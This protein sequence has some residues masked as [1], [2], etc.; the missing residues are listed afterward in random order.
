MESCPFFPSMIEIQAHLSVSCSQY[1]VT[2]AILWEKLLRVIP[3]T[4][5]TSLK[6]LP[7]QQLAAQLQLTVG[8]S[9]LLSQS[10]GDLTA[11][12][13]AY[14]KLQAHMLYFLYPSQT[15]YDESRF[16]KATV[17]FSTFVIF[18]TSVTSN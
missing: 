9:G 7:T 18:C 17:H 5:V 12:S 6:H 13:V 14:P 8:G 3:I 16:M 15:F 1:D 4:T 11:A 2:R 10:G